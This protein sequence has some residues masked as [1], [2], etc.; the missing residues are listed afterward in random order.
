MQ[1]DGGAV[2]TPP[3]V[4]RHWAKAKRKRKVRYIRKEASWT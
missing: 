3:R 1:R 2:T 4:A